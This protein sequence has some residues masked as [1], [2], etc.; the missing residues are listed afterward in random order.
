VTVPLKKVA[1]IAFVT[2]FAVPIAI[3]VLG[4]CLDAM[5]VHPG[6]WWSTAVLCVWPT[7][8]ALIETSNNLAGYVAFIISAVANGLLYS[9]IASVIGYYTNYFKDSGSE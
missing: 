4:R 8:L 2:G 5:N 6:M 1:V 3:E 9:F 7:G